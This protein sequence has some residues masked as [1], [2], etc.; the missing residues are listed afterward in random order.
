MSFQEELC[1][2]ESTWSPVDALPDFAGADAAVIDTETCD[3]DLEKH[4]P[5]WA[6]GRGFLAGISVTLVFGDERK[7]FY[8]PIAHQGGGNMSK[9]WVLGY[10][11]ELCADARILKVFHNAIYDLGWLSTAHI[12]V[13]GPI[14]DTMTAAALLDENRYSYSL[15]NLAREWCG[16][17]KD[18]TLLNEAAAMYGL[19]KKAKAGL[20]K[21]HAKY[22]GP[23]AEGDTEATYALWKYTA[24]ALEEEGLSE[25]L[26][27]ELGLLPML[28]EMRKRGIRVNMDAADQVSK[29]LA[30]M[31]RDT[32]AEINRKFGS[33]VDVW[34]SS[35]LA[36]AFDSAGLEYPLT[37]KGAPSFVAD[38]L[39]KHEHELPR[40][41][42]RV[43]KI[44]K[45]Q[46]TFIKGMIQ[47]QAVNGRIHCELHPLKSDKG[48]TVT[49]RFS[50][51]NPNL[52]QTSARDIE[53]GPMV[54]RLFLP[55]EWQR[56]YSHDYSTQESRLTVHYAALTHQ[57]GADDAVQ[58]YL[59]NPRMDYHQLVADMCGIERKPAKTIN[60][61]L[62]YGMGMLELCRRLGLPT[63]TNE[64][65]Y[66]MAG[67]EGTALMALYQEKVPFVGGL[68]TKC[69]NL[70]ADRGYIKTILGRKCR[71]DMWEPVG[72]K[73]GKFIRGR[74]AAMEKFGTEV[75]RAGTHKAMNRVIQ[76]SAAD[77][78]K[79]AMLLLYREG[80]L[81]MLQMHD[82]L[83][84]SSDS[85]KDMQKVIEI[86]ENCV[87]LKVPSIVD[88]DSGANWA[89]ATYS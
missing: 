14:Y 7:T 2:P 64:A 67:P 4:G 73:R 78:T 31:R 35:S 3:P 43:R 87:P 33:K 75:R 29:D 30:K 16:I 53:F 15:D 25:I 89:E 28:L 49:G 83:A 20:W 10:V 82:E 17:G 88:T 61:G 66:E 39:E 44:E 19:G 41:I 50:C 58:G 13:L 54:R 70:A 8:L 38:F 65:G 86:M 47:G 51:S 72:F 57:K 80:L 63:E 21:L 26:E 34:T 12:E 59:D 69:S 56:W 55:E 48:G 42:R 68:T 1:P 6:T 36:A 27:L 5:G 37:P 22:V 84:F 11:R 77:Q 40:M 76:G 46:S 18:E 71:F 79:K 81:P 52:Q 24:A 74:E 9:S 60:L 32:L 62:A 23:Y 45:T 85:E